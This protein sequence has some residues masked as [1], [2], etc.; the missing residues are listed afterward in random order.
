MV[1]AVIVAAGKSMRMGA[2]KSG[3]LLAG[4]PAL[5]R[6]LEAFESCGEVEYLCLVTAQERLEFCLRLAE[7]WGL[8]KLKSIVPGGDTR[9]A[10]VY[11]GLKALPSE[12]EI[13]VIQDG[14][15]PFT[16]PEIIQKSIG[17][18]RERGSGVAAMRCRDTV[19]AA[20]DDGLVEHTPDRRSLWLVQTPQTFQ[21]QMIRQ[22]YD[23]AA[24]EGIDATD[25]AAIAEWSGEKVFLVEGSA[26]NIKITTPEDIPHAE[27]IACARDGMPNCT[28]IGEGY[29]AHRLAQGRA[30]VLGGVTVPHEMGLLGHSDADVLAH[31]VM[32]ALL[33]AAG[34]GDIG[35]HF[36]DT[37]NAYKGIS[38]LLLLKRVAELLRGQGWQIGNV[39]ATVI[40]QRPR[41]AQYI[42]QMRENIARSLGISSGQVNVKATTTEGMGFEGREEGISARAT[43]LV[44]R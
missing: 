14:A 31:A 10:S 16:T 5:R 38:S 35:A 17:S 24:A 13:V 12:C 41:L 39:D 23:R 28:R 29:D 7:Q 4:K 25:D 21:Y 18:A 11:N 8:T 22:A 26:D 3:I 42:P 30:L 44:F 32:D 9:T 43:A 33:G 1:C 34:M 19:K 6:C 20:G 36:P 15:R 2:D 40:A 37:D 27:A